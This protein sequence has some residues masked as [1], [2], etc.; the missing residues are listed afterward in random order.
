MPPST[1]K[2]PIITLENPKS[3][4]SESYRMLRSNLDFTSFDNNEKILMVT[5][6]GPSEGK[7]TTTTN[8]AIVYAQSDKKVLLIDADLRKPTVHQTFSRS[9]RSGLS[10][11]LVGQTEWKECVQSTGIDN[12]S[13]ITSGPIPPNPSELL[14]SK[15]MGQFVEQVK[16]EFDVVL[17]DTPPTLAVTD[18]QV[19]ATNCSGVILVVDSGKTKKDAL[20]KAKATLD[21]ANARILG[22][23]L[24]NVSRGKGD[25][26]YYYYYGNK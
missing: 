10:N 3:P 16:G 14:S 9:N 26:Y 11:I 6:S 17:F 20:V 24:N 12:L 23:V 18:A 15:R 25:S 4:I 8:L 13:I 5:S 22:V 19:V 1:N 21:R 7:S 2:R